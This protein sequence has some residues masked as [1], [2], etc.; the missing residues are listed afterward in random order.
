MSTQHHCLLAPE[1]ASGKNPSQVKKTLM[2][3]GLKFLSQSRFGHR[4][5]SIQVG[6]T[7]LKPN[8]F[9]CPTIVLGTERDIWGSKRALTY[10]VYQLIHNFKSK[11]PQQLMLYLSLACTV[12]WAHSFQWQALCDHL[13]EL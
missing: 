9:N 13:D 6:P 5:W 2:A 12:K 1:V 8:S 3:F 4:L 7:F 10:D 11:A